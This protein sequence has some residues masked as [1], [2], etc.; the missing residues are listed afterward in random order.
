[1]KNKF[2]NR[3]LTDLIAQCKCI[4]CLN[5]ELPEA[6]FFSSAELPVI[7][8]DGAANELSDKGI[9]MDLIIGDLDSVNHHI[10]E[11]NQFIHM[12]SQDQS[13]FQK[14]IEY[15]GAQSMLPAFV[16]GISGYFLDHILNNISI[17][18]STECILYAPPI[19]GYMLK[20]YIKHKLILPSWTKISL[21]GMPNA[22]VSTQGL[23]WELHKMDLSLTSNNSCF[24][25]TTSKETIIEVFDGNVLMMAYMTPIDDLAS[26]DKEM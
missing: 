4:I 1:M 8:A 10:L 5:G 9:N 25:R 18:A 20:G 12:P 21:I 2:E 19:A 23:K 6:E 13:D 24:N 14:T 15:L 22:T 3:F 26:D 7:A 16:V 11:N 17:F